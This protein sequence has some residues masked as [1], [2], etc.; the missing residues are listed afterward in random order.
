MRTTKK[1]IAKIVAAHNPKLTAREMADKLQIERSV[2]YHVLKSRKLA[3]KKT[4]KWGKS[5]R[6]TKSQYEQLYKLASPDLTPAEL[7]DKI[8]STKARV[9]QWLFRNE[10]PYKNLRSKAEV[11]TDVFTWEW[12]EEVD[13][14]FKRA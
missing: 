6:L 13:H 9:Y 12:A 2:V 3:F 1:E 10:L 11:N 5:V 14:L 7:A 4:E 8:G